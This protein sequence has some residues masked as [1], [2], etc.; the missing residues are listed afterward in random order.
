[1]NLYHLTFLIPL[2]TIHMNLYH[3]TFLIPWY[4]YLSHELNV[5]FNFLVLRKLNGTYYLYEFVP[6][7][8]LNTMV[9][10]IDKNLYHLTFL[11]P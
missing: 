6:F 3:L 9:L 8:F 7:N 4:L 11:I 5:P 10:T 1:M 2:L